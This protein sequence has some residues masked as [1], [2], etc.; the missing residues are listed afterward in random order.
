MHLNVQQEKIAEL[1]LQ[2]AS[3]TTKIQS[4]ES[5]LDYQ[6]SLLLQKLRK[7]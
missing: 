7:K 2:N 6:T 5:Q 3:L 4:L 1:K